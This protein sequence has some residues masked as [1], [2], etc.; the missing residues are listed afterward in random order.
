MTH[1]LILIIAMLINILGM[2]VG[3][4]LDN[5]AAVIMNGF[6]L[7]ANILFFKSFM[8]PYQMDVFGGATPTNSTNNIIDNLR[9]LITEQPGLLYK[10]HDTVVWSYLQR[11][12]GVQDSISKEQFFDPLFPAADSIRRKLNDVKNV[13]NNTI[14]TT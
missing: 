12:H 9:T 7:I 5:T 4:V 2:L 1:E 8:N 6:L 11:F 10:D 14:Y 3:V 13:R